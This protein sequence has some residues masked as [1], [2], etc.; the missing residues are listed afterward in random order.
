MQSMQPETAKMYYLN[1][2]EN[3][4]L[5]VAGVLQAPTSNKV[6]YSIKLYYTQRFIQN[7]KPVLNLTRKN[8][9]LRNLTYRTLLVHKWV[10]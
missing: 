8:V 9:E 2:V 10:N 1:E 4:E 6:S 5:K 3:N 7:P